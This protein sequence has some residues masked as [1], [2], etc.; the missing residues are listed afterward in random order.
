MSD[1]YRIISADSHVSIPNELVQAHLPKQLKERFAE[2]EAAY[3]AQMLEAKPQKVKQNEL[4]EQ[5]A[6]EPL[7]AAMASLPNMGKGAPWPAAG[8][9]GGHDPL[10]RLKDMDIDGVEAEILYVGAGGAEFAR[11]APP[12]RMD[13][14]RAVNSAAMEWASVDPK[15]LMPVYILPI[16]DVGLAVKELERVVAEHGKA[17]QLPVLPREQGLPPYWDATYDALWEALSDVGVPISMHV[18][19]NSYLFGQVLPEDPTP[20]KGIFQ[21]L[22]P[23]HMSEL[24]ADW[25]ISGVLERWPDLRVVFV[26]AGIGWIPYFLE[27]LDNMADMHGW[28]TFPAKAITEKPSFYWY[29]NMAATFETDHVGMRLLD[30]I[31]YENLMW[32]T[33]YPHPDSTWPRSQEVLQEHFANLDRDKVELIAS[34]NATRIYKL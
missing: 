7:M 9:A 23:I 12:E 8:R 14:T 27:R 20:F 31:G 11:L 17:V 15:R 32:A 24:V 6:A 25:I 16:D 18:G 13:A 22:P 5:R 21:C 29:R 4:K 2:T 1:R 10:E 28:N 34:E 3:A 30:L 26:E 33:D 19:S